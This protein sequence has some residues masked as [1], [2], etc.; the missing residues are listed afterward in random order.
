[1]SDP[2]TELSA[3]IARL[4]A[5]RHLSEGTRSH[6]DRGLELEDLDPDPLR[7]FALWLSEALEAHPGW[8]N[9]MTLA[10]AGPDGVP[11]ARTVLLKAVDGTGFTFFT[12]HGSRKGR[13]L[14][15]NPRAAL[16]FYWASMARQVCVRGTVER[17][18][19]AESEVYFKTRPYGS[20]IGAWA[21]EQ[22]RPLGGRAEL[23]ERARAFAQRFGQDVPLP[24]H[25]GGYRLVP[26][27]IEFWKGRTDR[28]HDRFQ[29]ERVTD[30]WSIT[31][32]AP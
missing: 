16:V 30:G 12:N 5:R 6:E 18:G 28:L 27:T 22:S 9:S 8:P 25:W 2:F 15:A 21:S 7:Q 23:E 24:E 14:E 17:V 13:E 1:M 32:L 31:R 3:R 26:Q 4:E 19:R 29:Y 11:S 20:R 10:T